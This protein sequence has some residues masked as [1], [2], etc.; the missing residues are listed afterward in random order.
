MDRSRSYADDGDDSRE[1][2]GGGGARLVD[3]TL[4][5]GLRDADPAL[6]KRAVEAVSA[7][8]LD[9]VSKTMRVYTL[10]CAK[11]ISIKEMYSEVIE[12][13]GENEACIWAEKR[14]I[15]IFNGLWVT[16]LVLDSD[17]TD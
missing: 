3:V 16:S 12:T 11:S 17:P 4:G 10:R 13:R 8:L 2:G 14:F 1:G 6:F 9:Q 5:L 7:L 15:R